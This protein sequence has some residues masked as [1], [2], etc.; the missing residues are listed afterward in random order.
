MLPVPRSRRHD[1]GMHWAQREGVT[2]PYRVVVIGAGFGGIGL[3][4][5]LKQAGLDD[6]VVLDR[7]GDLGGTWRDNSYP[8]LCCDV[9]AHLYSFSFRPG[10]WSRRFPPREEILGYLHG[11]VAE[12]GLGPHLRFGQG[13]ETAEFDERRAVWRLTLGDGGTVRGGRG[14]L[15]RRPARTAGSAGHSGAGG[16]RR[17]VLAFGPVEP[18]GRPGRDAGGRGRHR[19]QRHPVRA[20]DRQGSRARGRVPA[21]RPVRAAQGRPALPRGRA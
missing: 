13:V 4:I 2:M 12:Y 21:Q 10:R 5:R 18:R 1:A 19:G 15:R 6:F 9:P 7:A 8:G 3:A 11:L 16:V 20:R 17:S 14:G